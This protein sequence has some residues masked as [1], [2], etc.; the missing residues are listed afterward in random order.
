MK[1][2]EKMKMFLFFLK[3]MRKS[4]ESLIYMFH[5]QLIE[6]KF[7]LEFIKYLLEKDESLINSFNKNGETPLHVASNFNRVEVVKIL[8]SRGADANAKSNRKLFKSPLHLAVLKNNAKLIDALIRSKCDVNVKDSMGLTPLHYAVN[9]YNF[10]ILKTLLKNNADVNAMDE[11]N[12]TPLHHAASIK[13]D[14]MITEL[15]K[16]GA[17]KNIKTTK[18]ESFIDIYN[19][20]SANK[21]NNLDFQG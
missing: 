10:S 5:N 1:S 16:Y 7:D 19:S 4:K 15:L 13:S 3:T 9:E 17:D 8:L 2:A 12:W 14:K 21:I 18:N 6:D 11:N 20:V